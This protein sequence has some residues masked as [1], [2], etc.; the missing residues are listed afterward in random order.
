MAKELKAGSYDT[1]TQVCN[2]NSFYTVTDPHRTWTRSKQPSYKQV[3]TCSA[4]TLSPASQ[5][6]TLPNISA[7]LRKALL[8]SSKAFKA[9][10]EQGKS[11]VF[12]SCSHKTESSNC[13][14]LLMHFLNQKPN[15]LKKIL[16]L[17]IIAIPNP[18][19]GRYF[20]TCE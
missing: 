11:L 3:L 19:I 20:V 6:L 4:K 5:N 12:Y 15:F 14:K 1:F 7:M 13:N 17:T 18:V 2:N 16:P 10:S 8:Y 9:I